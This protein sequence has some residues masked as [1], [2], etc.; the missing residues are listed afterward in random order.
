LVL[1]TNLC[2]WLVRWST[3]PRPKSG[4]LD[5]DYIAPAGV[6]YNIEAKFQLSFKTKVLQGVLGGMVIYGWPILKSPIGKSIIIF[7][8]FKKLMNPNLF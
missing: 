5:P 4:N 1:L 7:P 6:D 8:A 2:T 3:N